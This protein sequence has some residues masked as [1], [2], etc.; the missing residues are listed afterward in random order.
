MSQIARIVGLGTY[1]PEKILSNKDFEISLE[2]TDEWIT[3]RTGIKE[4]RI[5]APHEST[6]D[7]AA[8]AAKQALNHAKLSAD[9]IDLIIVATMTPDYT[10]SSA[11]SLV[12]ASIGATKAGAIDMQAACT[13]FIYGLATA[14]AYIESGIFKN[15]LVIAAEKMSSIVDYEDRAT[16][17]LFGDGA[18]AV[19]VSNQGEGLQLD[20]ISLG[21]DGT[22]AE[23]GCIPAGGS[24]NPATQETVAAKQHFIKMAGKEVFKHAVR[25]M[26]GAARDCLEKANIDKEQLSWLVPHQA[27]IRIM[28]AVAKSFD[29]PPE[30]MYR[31]LHKYGNTSAATIAI[32]LKELVKQEKIGYG[33]HI[34]LDAFGFG[35]TWGAILLTKIQD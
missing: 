23:L 6:S 31:T 2:T 13:G 33:E 25:R 35:L 18:G 9:H 8:E 12:Q 16:C 10:S 19:V 20:A 3:T 28:E 14:K 7:L 17:I 26:E 24:K 30:K 11:A 22:L 21:S 34:L 15:I 29:L 5:A 1:L 32:A 4:R 27:N